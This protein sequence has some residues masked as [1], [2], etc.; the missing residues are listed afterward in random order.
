MKYRIEEDFLGKVKVPAD[1]YYGAQTARAKQ[2]FQIT[3]IKTHRELI[4]SIGIVKKCAAIVNISLGNLDMKIGS[5]IIKAADE[6]I[7]GKFNDEFCLDVIQGGAGTANHM[8]VNE[9]IANRAIELLGGKKGDYSIVHP[10]DHVNRSQSTNDVIP[11][12]I[13]ITSLVLISKLQV[14]LAKLKESLKKKAVEFNDIVKIGRTHLQDAVPITLGQEFNS[15]ATKI[16]G[17]ID[18][19]KETN[20]FLQELGIGGTAIGTGINAHKSYTRRM[21]GEL[22]KTTDL[23]FYAA[24][25][26]I[27]WTQS[28]SPF[29]FASSALKVLAI[30]LIKISNDLRLLSSGPVGGINEISLP[31]VAQGSSIMPG[32]INP[33]IAE[34][35][36]MV[37]FQVMGNDHIICLAAQ[38]GQLELNV[39]SPL[40]SFNLLQSLE[41][42]TNAVKMFNQK[43]IIGIKA[44]KER[45]EEMAAKNTMIAT[46]LIPYLGYDNIARIVKTAREKNKSVR[47]IILEENL[48]PEKDIKKILSLKCLTGKTR[49]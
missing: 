24:K 31:A 4:K 42:L 14:E 3:G 6:V 10:N 43:C 36:D 46:A 21:I 37:G 5:A 35:V 18:K 9:V 41:I 19:L 15:F 29:V 20:Y 1:A 13:R 48:L 32:K 2:N 11:T 39:M 34:T 17:S 26:M 40:I 30:D 8:N 45:C 16:K 47:D 38:A 12:A 49:D 25:D 7:I 22:N 27:H 28:M 33:V 23:K 44:N